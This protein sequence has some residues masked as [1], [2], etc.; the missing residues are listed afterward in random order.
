MTRRIILHFLLSALA[1]IILL[2]FLWLICAAFKSGPDLFDSAFLPWNHLNRLT[3]ANFTDLFQH[4]Q[5]GTWLINS[6][7]LSSAYTVLTV[8]LCSMAGF[9]LAK[10]RFRGK[11]IIVAGMIA[12]LLIP[13]QVLLPGGYDLIYKIGWI[14]SYWAILIPGA[15]SVLGIFLFRQ[16]M[17]SVPDEL[18]QCA[19]LDGCPEW[20]LWWEIALPIVR[21]MVG[22]YTLLSFL[23]SWNSFLW[24]QIV[25]QTEQKYTLPI[26]LNNLN[27]LPGYQ[28]NF[29]ILMAATLLSILP[30]A[31]LF[32]A[33]QRDFISGLS[34]GA[35]KG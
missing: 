33:L 25:L 5:F 16:A 32:F 1:A 13:S 28:Q 11:R 20:R 24:P 10:Y 7:F 2:P 26:A 14:D 3:L 9:A 12:T 15:A 17:L 18:L 21:P 23:A 31:I 19:R 34:T 35:V 30:V 4:E 27:S 8:I 6:I 22:A 29:G